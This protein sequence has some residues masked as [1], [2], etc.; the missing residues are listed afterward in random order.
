M[1]MQGPM[2][3]LAWTQDIPHRR[4]R[5]KAPTTRMVDSDKV[6]MTT[7]T[8]LVARATECHSKDARRPEGHTDRA[9]AAATHKTNHDAHLDHYPRGLLTTT[10]TV[11]RHIHLDLSDS[12]PPTQ[13]ARLRGRILN[14]S[15]TRRLIRRQAL[16]TMRASTSA[17][18]IADPRQ[19][20]KAA[21]R[22]TRHG[23]RNRRR[24][25]IPATKLT[26]LLILEGSSKVGPAYDQHGDFTNEC[27]ITA[28][29]AW[30]EADPL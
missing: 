5:R 4:G 17:R 26:G 27:D 8:E 2:V 3:R 30:L 28:S 11:N 18:A 7:T 1:E 21:Q 22:R 13:R 19:L 24:A 10:V 25:L 9:P 29:M 15:M 12:T 6:V 16:R 23:L 20:A 14:D